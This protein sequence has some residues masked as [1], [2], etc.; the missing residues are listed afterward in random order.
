MAE[1]KWQEYAIP[2]YIKS[3]IHPDNLD[4]SNNEDILVPTFRLPTLIHSRSCKAKWLTEI[5]YRNPI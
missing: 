4:R 3:Y 1:W 5:S 2:G